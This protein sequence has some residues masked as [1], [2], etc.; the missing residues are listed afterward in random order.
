MSEWDP[1]ATNESSADGKM[2][3]DTSVPA[4]KNNDGQTARD[5]MFQGFQNLS[6]KFQQGSQ[7]LTTKFQQGTQEYFSD[8]RKQELA[9]TVQAFGSTLQESGRHL[10]TKLQQGTQEVLQKERTQEL[11]GNVQAF[12]KSTIEQLR[13]VTVEQNHL[14]APEPSLRDQLSTL[15][16]RMKE[17]ADRRDVRQASEA[18]CLAAMRSH[19]VGFLEEDDDATYEGWILAFHPENTQ[20][21]TLLADMEHREVDARFYVEESDHRILWNELVSEP[22]RQVAA[23]TAMWGDAANLGTG[24][25]IDLL[26][27]GTATGAESNDPSSTNNVGSNGGETDLFGG[28]SAFETGASSTTSAEL[29]SSNTPDDGN[30]ISL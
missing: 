18:A 27:S 30:L 11:V 8:D 12:G 24:E 2:S 26:D 29:T 10:R 28:L 6:T 3:I 20:D 21:V 17:E 15:S 14:A 4:G 13:K 1:F 7:R 16:R 9:G 5:Q 19:L 22:S 23:R 25:V